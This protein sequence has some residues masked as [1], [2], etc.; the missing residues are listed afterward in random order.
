MKI[1]SPN[2]TQYKYIESLQKS[3]LNVQKKNKIS[4]IGDKIQQWR[5]IRNVSVINTQNRYI[6]DC[7]YTYSNSNC[8]I[9][10]I[11]THKLVKSKRK[12][13]ITQNMLNKI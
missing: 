9:T 3:K 8:T 11:I 6:S 7:K 5:C 12:T 2:L 13:Q 4:Q 10:R 1:E